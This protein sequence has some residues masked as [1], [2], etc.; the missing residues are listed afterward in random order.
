MRKFSRGIFQ[1]L[2]FVVT[3]ALP[4]CGAHRSA[5]TVHD[6]SPEETHH[7]LLGVNPGLTAV[8]GEAELTLDWMGREISLPGIYLLHGNDFRLEILA[9]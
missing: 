3:V 4:G 7:R 1:L 6:P 5:G 8:R 9:V 2:L